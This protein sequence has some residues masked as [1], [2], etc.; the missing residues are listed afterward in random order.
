MECG[1]DAKNLTRVERDVE[2]DDDGGGDGDDDDD[3]DGSNNNNND[4]GYIITFEFQH[5]FYVLLFMF[6][7]FF[8]VF[9]RSFVHSPSIFRSLARLVCSNAMNR[10]TRKLF[11]RKFLA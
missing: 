10:T 9:I 1:D 2:N 3:D 7:C 8:L 4:D 11:F 6:G 5:F